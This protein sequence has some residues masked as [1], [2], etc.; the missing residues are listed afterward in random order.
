MK[1]LTAIKRLN[2]GLIAPIVS[3]L[4][5]IVQFIEKE[6]ESMAI[7][8]IYDL[9]Q[10][11]KDKQIMKFDITNITMTYAKSGG[12]TIRGIVNGQNVETHT[13]DSEVYDWYNDDTEAELHKSAILHCEWKLEE[14]FLDEN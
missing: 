14:A 4:E 6:N 12:Y 9:L 7:I 5:R 1:R 2:G 10:T 11:L 3:D 13:N 8:L